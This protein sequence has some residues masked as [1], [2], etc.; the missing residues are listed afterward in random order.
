MQ[1]MNIESA[2]FE[3]TVANEISKD[4]RRAVRQARSD[5]ARSKRKSVKKVIETKIMNAWAKAR[6]EK[7]AKNK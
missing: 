6:R 3:D 2:D 7:K 1:D 5:A 4:K